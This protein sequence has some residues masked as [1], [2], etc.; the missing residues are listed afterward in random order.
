MTQ[1]IDLTYPIHEGMT[2][3]PAPWHPLVS[4]KQLG[5][6]PF[7]GRESRQVTLGTHTGTQVD[8]P[9]HFIPG[10]RSI[11][12]VPLTK[13]VGPVSILDFSAL[14]ENEA[15]TEEM[16]KHHE[17]GPRVLIRFGW[18]KHWGTKK[19]YDGY[20]FFSAEAAHSLV[21]RGVELVGF[22]TPSPD[23]SRTKLQG[24]VL[25]TAAD[26]P[27]HK[28]FL[29]ANVALLEYVA[30]LDTV[31]ELNGWQIAALP[32]PIRGADGSPARV[33]LFR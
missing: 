23:D 12:E 27:I 26:S 13:L 4:V 28:I 11:D 33:C 32:L 15:L 3:F 22:D 6:I 10:G 19:F 5:R 2:S 18:G 24:D 14:G 17:I 20:P 25:G 7:E 8:A 30:N 21:A 9:R 16:L 1:I 29:N 31:S